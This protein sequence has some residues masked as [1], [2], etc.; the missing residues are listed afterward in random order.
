MTQSDMSKLVRDDT[1]ELFGGDRTSLELVIKPTGY[2]N[3]SIR[4]GQ[5]VDRGDFVDMHLDTGN[6]ERPRHAHAHLPQGRVY[7]F[8][9]FAVELL[10]GSPCGKPIHCKPV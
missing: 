10:G 4:R 3:P 5:T 6:I 9:G 2:E 8:G 1:G 7:Q